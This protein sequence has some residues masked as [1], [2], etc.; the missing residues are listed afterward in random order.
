MLQYANLSIFL[1]HPETFDVLHVFL[2]LTTAELS[3]LKQV[4][5][6]G[7]PCKYDTNIRHTVSNKRSAKQH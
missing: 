2:P 1:Q 5:F 6:F 7:P 3:M 4:R